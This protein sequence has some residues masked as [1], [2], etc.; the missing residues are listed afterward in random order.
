MK[1]VRSW[2]SSCLDTTLLY[3]INGHGNV[4]NFADDFVQ[5][6]NQEA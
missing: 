6:I 4:I 2:L 5:E 1:Q 3:K